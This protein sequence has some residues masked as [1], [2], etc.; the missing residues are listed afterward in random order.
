[1]KSVA[2]L[3]RKPMVKVAPKRLEGFVVDIGAGGE[4]VIAKTCG[5]NTVGVDI[6]KREI[7]EAR[8]RGS[9]AHWVLCDAC[10]MPFRNGSF[11]VVTLFFSLMYI[12]TPERKRSVFVE[13]KRVLK[14]DGQLCL[15]DAIIRE[16]PDLYVVFVEVGLPDGEEIFTGYGVRGR[17]KG[18]NLELIKK[19]A[20]EA[21][22]KASC[23]ESHRH[24]IKACFHTRAS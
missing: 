23:A 15:W 24:L 4:G 7:N 2:W 3:S 20:L 22:F 8:S 1:M 17:E 19:L 16:K 10:S 9:L 21:G 12:K 6:N 5:S 11:D 18:Q 13:A 14:S